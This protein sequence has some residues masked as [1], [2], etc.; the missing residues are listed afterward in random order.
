MSKTGASAS[1]TPSVAVGVPRKRRAEKCVSATLMGRTELEQARNDEGRVWLTMCRPMYALFGRKSYCSFA[2][3]TPGD[4][5]DSKALAMIAGL[6]RAQ[7]I[8]DATTNL[9]S[10]RLLERS[11]LS[12]SSCRDIASEARPHAHH[13]DLR[14]PNAITTKHHAKV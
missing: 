10:I 14:P 6:T 1:S 8:D 11:S 7:S 2:I 3:Q 12:T 4:V 13:Q 9:P 5:A